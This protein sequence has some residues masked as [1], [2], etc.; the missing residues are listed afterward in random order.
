MQF[1]GRREKR[2]E[3]SREAKMDFTNQSSNTTLFHAINEI[4]CSEHQSLLL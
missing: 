4:S 2:R 1:V 3:E